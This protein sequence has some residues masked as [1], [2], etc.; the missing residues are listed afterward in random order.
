MILTA[1]SQPAFRFTEGC[2][3]AYQHIIALRIQPAIRLITAE[4]K[5]DPQ[6]LVPLLLDNYIDCFELFLNEDPSRFEKAK[7]SKEQRLEHMRSGPAQSPLTLLSQAII[8]LQWAAVNY[9]F[10]QKWSA[11][12]AFR[13]AFKLASTN[14]KKFPS[15]LPNYMITGPLEM[16][17]STIPDQLQ[18]LGN[19]MGISGTMTGGKSRLDQFMKASATDGWSRFFRNEGIF[20]QVYLQYYLLN[21]PDEALA[22]IKQYQL[23]VVNNHLFAYMSAN[24]HLNNRQSSIT[25]KIVLERK[26]SPEYLATPLWDFEMAHALLF[27]LEPQAGLYFHRFLDQF[28]GNFYVKDAWLKLAYHYLISGNRTQYRYCLEQV[29][30]RGEAASDADKKALREAKSGKEPSV[31]LLKARLLCDG[32]YA[33]EALQLLAGKTREMFADDGDK[34]EWVYRMGRIYDELGKPEI[35]L[36]YYDQAFQEGRHRT[37]YFAARSALQSGMLWEKLGQPFKAL[38][39]YRNCISLKGYDYENSIEQK[40]RAGL[41]RCSKR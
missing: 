12:W 33:G 36:K 25:R 1:Q 6:N 9:K 7:A 19:L 39:A 3:E 14:Q 15:F 20:Y 28:R 11:G 40:A 18:W 38:Q 22:L 8:H 21:Q 34:L 4:K 10:N 23:D 13:D 17:A 5:A 31:W 32:G 16:V 29:K 26:Q 30:K 24:L 35:A 37:E 27:H 41:Q 2:T